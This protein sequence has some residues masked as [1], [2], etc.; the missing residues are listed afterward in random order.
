MSKLEQSLNQSVSIEVNDGIERHEVRLEGG[1]VN[2]DGERVDELLLP[3]QLILAFSMQ[4][5]DE[6]LNWGL[7]SNETG[8]NSRQQGLHL[9]NR[10]I[11]PETTNVSRGLSIISAIFSTEIEYTGSGDISVK[12]LSAI[13]FNQTLT[14]QANPIVSPGDKNEVSQSTSGNVPKAPLTELIKPKTDSDD[15]L[16]NSDSPLMKVLLSRP[17]GM[18]YP[19]IIQYLIDSQAKK[20][21]ILSTQSAHRMAERFFQEIKD[22]SGFAYNR[23]IVGGVTKAVV[24]RDKPLSTYSTEPRNDYRL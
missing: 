9:A 17:A 1:V 3:Q 11:L 10:L 16:T 14:N 24:T 20:G 13:R 12:G 4:T 21:Q 2:F 8:V 22:R 18:S 15:D 23:I 6:E 19:E 7:I 5:P